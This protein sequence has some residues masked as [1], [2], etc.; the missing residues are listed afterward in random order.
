MS[1]CLSPDDSASRGQRLQMGAYGVQAI[2]TF[3]QIKPMSRSLGQSPDG[4]VDHDSY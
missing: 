1:S 2:K 3:E 4:V